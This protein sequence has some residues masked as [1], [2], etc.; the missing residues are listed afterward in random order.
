MKVYSIHVHV[1]VHVYV[2]FEIKFAENIKK[3]SLFFLAV[4]MNTY[5]VHTLP[6]GDTYLGYEMG[7]DS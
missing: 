1:H 7:W 5:Q 3:K 4:I 6:E 2:N